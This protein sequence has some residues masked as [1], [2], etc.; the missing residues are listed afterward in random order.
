MLEAEIDVFSGMPNPTFELSEKEEKEFLDRIVADAGQ[1]SAVADPAENFGLG[2]RGITI[3]HFKTDTGAWSMAKRPKDLSIDREITAS[4]D[5]LPTEFRLG[6]RAVRAESAADWL[7]KIA[8]RKSLDISD[9]VRD[10]LHKGVELLPRTREA[11]ETPD[12]GYSE[13][14]ESRGLEAVPRG[15]KWLACNSP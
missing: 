5:A 13:V 10:V 9:E 6:S 8:E 3:R 7:L 14:D 15:A 1:M 11:E 4:P 2:Y 12:E